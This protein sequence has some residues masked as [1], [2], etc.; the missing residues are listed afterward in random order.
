MTTDSP[1]C[2]DEIYVL[3][4]D[5]S[6]SLRSSIFDP[7]MEL[8]RRRLHEPRILFSGRHL[9]SGLQN[10]IHNLMPQLMA[11]T[12]RA[13]A[14]EEHEHGGFLHRPSRLQSF[15]ETPGGKT[16]C[17][18]AMGCFVYHSFDGREPLLGC[19]EDIPRFHSEDPEL[20]GVLN[21]RSMLWSNV[22]NI[23]SGVVDASQFKGR[24]GVLC[25]CKDNCPAP[26]SDSPTS[27]GT[28]F[29]PFNIVL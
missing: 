13:G 24:A 8:P 10:I 28:G 16:E 18:T 1:L 27:E 2:F 4:S 7:K 19:I 15:C 20:R 22:A 12:G 29:Q 25:C 6:A 26:I 17:M 3:D 9:P 21:C 5:G 23:C 14:E 11:S